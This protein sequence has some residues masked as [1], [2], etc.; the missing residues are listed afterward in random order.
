MTIRNGI[1]A[2]YEN[3][4]LKLVESRIEVPVSDDKKTFQLWYP[5]LKDCPFKDFEKD[6]FG[7][8]FYKTIAI[9]QIG[10]AF[11]VN[12]FGKYKK[13]KVEVFEGKDNKVQIASRNLII[14]EELNLIK[15]GKEWYK[16]EVEISNLNLIWEEKI[17]IKKAESLYGEILKLSEIWNDKLARMKLEK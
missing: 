17:E 8:G 11:L 1:F 9:S 12:T 7:Q 6:R 10:K 13:L 15:C 5:N 4:E 2:K 14:A 3:L 16:N